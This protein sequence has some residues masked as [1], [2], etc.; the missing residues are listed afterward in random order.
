MATVDDNLIT[1][2][3]NALKTHSRTGSYLELLRAAWD[4]SERSAVTDPQDGEYLSLTAGDLTYVLGADAIV[5][6]CDG[7]T[8]HRTGWSKHWCTRSAALRECCARTS[9]HGHGMTLEGIVRS[10]SPVSVVKQ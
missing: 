8:W 5:R 3:R 10:Y 1:N 7:D 4:I 9:T 6:D 2:L